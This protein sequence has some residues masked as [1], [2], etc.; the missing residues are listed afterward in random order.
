VGPPG[1]EPGTFEIALDALLLSYGPQRAG[2]VSNPRPSGPSIRTLY[3][4]SYQR[5]TESPVTRAGS[6]GGS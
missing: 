6:A 2:Q 5:K 4:L 3:Q 1:F